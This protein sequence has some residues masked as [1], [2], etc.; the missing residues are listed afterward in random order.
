MKLRGMLKFC[1]CIPLI[2]RLR[3]CN[4]PSATT[5]SLVDLNHLGAAFEIVSIMLTIGAMDPANLVAQACVE[6]SLMNR[7]EQPHRVLPPPN[8][9]GSTS[10]PK[11]FQQNQLQNWEARE[12]INIS[13]ASLFC[14]LK[15]ICC[16]CQMGGPARTQIV[17]VDMIHLVTFLFAHYDVIREEMAA[18]IY[19]KGGALYSN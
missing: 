4:P 9:G 2:P 6:A 10:Y 18:V 13:R 15:R 5:A 11:W 16:C 7:L 3:R 1:T 8:N 14:W 12:L 17:D 19:N